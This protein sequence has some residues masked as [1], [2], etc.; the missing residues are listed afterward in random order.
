MALEVHDRVPNELARAV[1]G[2]V[3]ATLHFKKLDASLR[4][5]LARAEQVLLLGAPPEYHHRG[6]LD[7]D[8]Q[9]L[10]ERS[11]NSCARRRALEFQRLGVGH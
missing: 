2:D 7:E 9:V 6:M 11:I 10:R 1:E 8:Q 3:A 4:E 5:R